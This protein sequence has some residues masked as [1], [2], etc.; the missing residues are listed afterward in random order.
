MIIQNL[1]EFGKAKDAGRQMQT[2]ATV[3]CN[4]LDRDFDVSAEA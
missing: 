3:N 1:E 4:W 2:R